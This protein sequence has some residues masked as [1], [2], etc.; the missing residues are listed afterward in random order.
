MKRPRLNLYAQVLCWFFLNLALVAVV[1][2]VVLRLHFGVDPRQVL[3]GRTRDQF[4]AVVRVLG[5]ELRRSPRSDWAGILDSY[6]EAYG[7]SFSVHRAGTGELLD[8]SDHDLPGELL[9]SVREELRPRER[10]EVPP[11]GPAGEAPPEL[12]PGPR[13]PGGGRIRPPRSEGP[14]GLGPAGPPPGAQPVR[15]VFVGR[16]GE[17]KRYWAAALVPLGSREF[18]HPPETVVVASASRLAGNKVFTDWGPWL[19]LLGAVGLCSALIWLP[20]VGRLSRRVR[21]LTE[22]A[23]SISEGDFAVEVHSTRRDELGRLSRAVQRM[24]Q[25]LDEHLTG[26]KRFLG[27]IAHELCSPLAR[28]RMALGILEARIPDADHRHLATLNEEAEE[29]SKLI[30]ELL[31]YSRASLVPDQL[32]QQEFTVLDLVGELAEREGGGATFEMQVSPDLRVKTNRDLL[33]RALANVIRNAGRYAGEA[34]PITIAAMCS[35]GELR[36]EVRDRG[37]GLAPEW[38]ERIFEPFARPERARTREG[39]GAG[40]GLAIARTCMLALGGHITARNEEGGGLCVKLVLP[41]YLLKRDEQSEAS[42]EVV[43][44]PSGP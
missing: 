15:I 41:S 14:P 1:L 4:D 40:L 38:L 30:N 8:G 33:A 5:A 7:V 44:R 26:Q 31:D 27:D 34:G 43:H 10:A 20:F 22:A 13:L 36:L 28:L 42:R 32:P 37:P 23:E 21:R 2:V 12:D 11:H 3:E 39:G 19:W 35:S 29:L 6:G 17:P 25:R 16:A 9:E 24:A 18:R